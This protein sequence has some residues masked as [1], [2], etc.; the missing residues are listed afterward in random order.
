MRVTERLEIK[1]MRPSTVPLSAVE[2]CKG[3]VGRNENECRKTS[4]VGKFV[5]TPKRGD[6][7]VIPLACSH[8][9]LGPHGLTMVLCAYFGL[10]CITLQLLILYLVGKYCD[11]LWV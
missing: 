9:S 4:A 6:E 5:E 2:L 3:Q 11:V 1:D 7:G 10:Q 8:G